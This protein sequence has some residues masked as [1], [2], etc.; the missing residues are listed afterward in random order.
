MEEVDD[1]IPVTT[2]PSAPTNGQTPVVVETPE[3]DATVE[4]YSVLQKALGF[5][6][7]LGCIG[8]YLRMSNKK[9]KRFL[10]KS[11]V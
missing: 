8:G 11:L 1:E 10:E 2:S 5:A 9:N 3:V 4:G 7:I 6:V